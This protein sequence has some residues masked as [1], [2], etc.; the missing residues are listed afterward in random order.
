M[1][2]TISYN[3]FQTNLDATCQQVCNEHIPILVERILNENIVLMP[4]ADY[5]SLLETAHLLKSATNAK[6]LLESLN[7]RERDITFNSI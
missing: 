3:Q 6:R 1:N 4:E 7:N 2:Q 5:L